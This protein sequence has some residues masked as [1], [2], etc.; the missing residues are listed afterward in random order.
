[1]FGGSDS[2]G[3]YNGLHTWKIGDDTTYFKYATDYIQGI[4]NLP[5]TDTLYCMSV[6]SDSVEIVDMGTWTRAGIFQLEDIPQ[7]LYLTG[8]GYTCWGITF[9]DTTILIGYS[10]EQRVYE[11][12]L[13]GHHTL[14]SIGVGNYF[15]KYGNIFYGVWTIKERLNK[16]I[17]II[18]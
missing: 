14:R 12:G 9:V 15:H 4:A 18:N 1:M 3:A 6:E 2:L 5:G 17:I 8:Q 13:R 10:G 16:P 7:T 11:I